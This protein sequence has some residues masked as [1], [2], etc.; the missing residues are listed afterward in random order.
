LHEVA[1]V[2]VRKWP[3]ILKVTE[4]LDPPSMH[5]VPIGRNARL[6]QMPI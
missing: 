3:E 2:L 1:A 4:L 6:R 5:E